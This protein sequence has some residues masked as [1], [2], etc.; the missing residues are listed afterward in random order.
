LIQNAEPGFSRTLI[1]TV[2]L[3]GIRHGEALGLKWGDIDLVERKITIRRTWP[4]KWRNN[5]PVFYA[6]KS[7]NGVREIPDLPSELMTALKRWKLS[8]PISKWDLVFPKKDGMPQDRKSVLRSALYPAIRRAKVKKLNMHALRH[9]FAS[10]LLSQRPPTPINEVSS[11]LGHSDPMIT[12]KIYTH[13]FP[14]TKTASIS[15]LAETVFN[16]K[17]T[18]EDTKAKEV[19]DVSAQKQS[20]A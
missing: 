1:L 12:L 15:R 11:Y 2:A 4:D 9:T 5:E 13:W 6:P 17:S 14:E 19:S 16:A 10:L 8:C 20:E 7:K 18:V 3:T